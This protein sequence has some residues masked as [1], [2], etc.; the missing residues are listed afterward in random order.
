VSDLTALQ[1]EVSEWAEKRWPDADI[2]S[3]IRKLTEEVG[4][5][6]EAAARFA[7]MQTDED[8]GETYHHLREEAADCQLVLLHIFKLLGIDG[9][10]SL[11][12]HCREVWE[13][14]KGR[15]N[16]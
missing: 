14:K 13:S 10:Y 16:R 12:A 9:H 7:S 8:I 4:E 6:A 2:L 15:A 5:L 3:K 1:H 11:A